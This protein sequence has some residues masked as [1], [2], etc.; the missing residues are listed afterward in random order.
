MRILVY[1][2]SFNPPHIGHVRSVR[3]AA[4]SLRPDRIFLVPTALP[5][6]KMLD[7]HSPPADERLYMTRLA[8]GEVP[9]AE[10]LDIEL[11][12][13]GA[14]YTAHTITELKRD[15]PDAELIFLMGTDML[16]SFS[17]WYHPEIIADCA[18]LAVFSR[19]RGRDAEIKSTAESLHR[20]YGA[21]VYII[22]GDPVDISSSEL[23]ALL[24]ERGGSDM[25]PPDVYARI[26]QKRLYNAKPSFEWLR[27]Q[28]YARLKPKRVAHV[29]GVEEEAVRLAER[30]DARV[31]DAR[32]AAI[33]HDITK[34]LD[35]TEQLRLCV[36][37]AI[38]TNMTETAGEKLLHAKTGAALAADLFGLS[39]EVALAIR[40]HTTGRPGMTT[41]EMITYLAD[42]IEPG[43][44]GFEGLEE[45][46]R[47]SY[48][49]LD[50]A[51]ELAM[52]MSLHEVRG[53]GYPAHSDTVDGQR[54]YLNC[55]RRRGLSPAH[56]DGIPDE[57]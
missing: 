31:D 25:I 45:L 49:D 1:G 50:Q 33:C 15:W 52:R 10:I 5:P 20:R 42:Y 53:K 39:A 34:N 35:K 28:V 41:L 29:K 24:P 44:E 9:G 51:M 6:H 38:M 8:F 12:R 2:G 30:W 56:A 11:K 13:R 37:Y 22:D 23:R 27:G 40:F 4:A 14:S 36:K 26:V 16:L 43:R 48:Q 46:R 55:L 57:I 17:S 21:P 47:T 3:A 7:L 19:Q 18:S 54:W 32:E